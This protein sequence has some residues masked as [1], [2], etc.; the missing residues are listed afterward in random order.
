[1]NQLD[2]S[3]ALFITGSLLASKEPGAYWKMS[4]IQPS[5]ALEL[6]PRGIEE[7]QGRRAL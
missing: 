5:I 7:M 3:L 2:L 6:M 4:S 1:M